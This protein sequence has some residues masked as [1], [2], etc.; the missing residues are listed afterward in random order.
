LGGTPPPVAGF[1]ETLSAI[2]IARVVMEKA[3]VAGLGCFLL[4]LVLHVLV[5]RF[6][7]LKE[8]F[9]TLTVI[10]YALLPVYV[11]VYFLLPGPRWFATLHEF[12]DFLAGLF[13]YIFLFLGYCQFYFIVDRSISVR[14]MME[15]NNT[16]GEGRAFEELKRLYS[17]D[18]ILSRRL[19]HMVYGGYL[20]KEGERYVNTK[21][22]RIVASVF[23]FLKDFLRLGP[24][25]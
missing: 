4:F 21:K 1:F 19:D 22:G 11:A 23:A 13:L 5:F 25:G 8:R 24:G 16:G 15:I 6:I 20:D 10:F 12:L 7:K 3:V 18:Y 17:F 2:A 9:R 14:V